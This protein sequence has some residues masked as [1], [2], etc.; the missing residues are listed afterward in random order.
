[1]YVVWTHF[2]THICHIIKNWLARPQFDIFPYSPH[3]QS[4]SQSQSVSCYYS[5]FAFLHFGQILDCTK[6]VVQTLVRIQQTSFDSSNMHCINLRT[7]AIY[8]LV[9]L[10][11]SLPWII[12]EIPVQQIWRFQL[13]ISKFTLTWPLHLKL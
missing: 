9:F 10:T 2:E 7:D 4:Q 13:P 8:S 12:R 3:S 1:M 11:F 5:F 6:K